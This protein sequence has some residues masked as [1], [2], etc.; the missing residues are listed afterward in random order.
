MDAVAQL[1]VFNKRIVFRRE[2]HPDREVLHPLSTT[3]CSFEQAHRL[4]AV[5]PMLITSPDFQMAQRLF[6]ADKLGSLK[7]ANSLFH[8]IRH[9]DPSFPFRQN[10]NS[11]L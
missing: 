5:E 6:I 9:F 7:R 8:K 2:A 10:F 11:I 3:V 1:V 4:I